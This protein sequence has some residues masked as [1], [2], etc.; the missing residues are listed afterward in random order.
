[1]DSALTKIVEKKIAERKGTGL[2]SFGK[3]RINALQKE[4][5]NREITAGEVI[6]DLKKEEKLLCLR[7]KDFEEIEKEISKM[8]K[9]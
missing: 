3:K 6:Y 4:I 8:L 2:T 9:R 5:N 7:D 1:M